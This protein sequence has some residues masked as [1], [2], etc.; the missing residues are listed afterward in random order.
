MKIACNKFTNQ[1]V[2]LLLDND[3]ILI[4][5]DNE[6]VELEGGFTNALDILFKSFW[7]FQL[8]Y[9]ETATNVYF[10]MERCLN[11]INKNTRPKVNEMFDILNSN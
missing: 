4:K 5:L 9:P 11:I 7:V 1:P 10:F 8:E 3:Q 6:L 2:L